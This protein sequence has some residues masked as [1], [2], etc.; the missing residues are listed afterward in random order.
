M[1]SNIIVRNLFGYLFLF[2][3]LGV[4][5][6]LCRSSLDKWKSVVGISFLISFS[7][8]IFKEITKIGVGDIDDII[9]ACIGT[10][11]GYGIYRLCNKLMNRKKTSSG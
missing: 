2:L 9:L 1:N 11:I 3:P 4:L 10:M 5:L 8:Q 6:P 7:M